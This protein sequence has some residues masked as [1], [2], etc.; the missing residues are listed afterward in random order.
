MLLTPVQN[1]GQPATPQKRPGLLSGLFSPD[2]RDRFKRLAIGLEGMTLNP[3]RSLI[4]MLQGD[5]DKKQTDEA[6]NRTIAWLKSLNT[7]QA[8][9]AAAAL[10]AG[11]ID[12]ST[13]VQMG[14][15]ADPNAA[16]L[17][18]TETNNR[19]I[20]WL[21]S[22]N[23]PQA[24]QAAEALGTGSID[25][26]SAVKMALDKPVDNSTALQQNIQYFMG[27]PFN[28][29]AEDAMKA[30]QGP[31]NG[32]TVNVGG[33][34]IDYGDPPKEMAWARNPDG[35][36]KLDERGIPV[37]MP[38]QNT[39]LATDAQTAA[40]AADRKAANA[41][42]YGDA[43]VRAID[44]LVGADGKPGT[45]A[46]GGLFDL[47]QAGIMGSALASM[48]INQEAVDVKNTLDTVTSNIAF[49]RLQAMRDA[50]VTG[51]ALGSV[52][53]NELALLMNSL[54]AVKQNTSPEKLIENL[55]EI[56]RIWSK[57]NNDP[58]ARAAYVAAGGAAG[59]GAA[60]GAAGGDG[61][62]VTGE[63]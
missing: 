45:L 63:N 39:P 10:E 23:T 17:K 9:K 18:A 27:P 52:T 44:E 7:P 28:M 19:T 35:S 49:G 2:N 29:S 6:T 50:S 24:M 58:V 22:M 61:F 47:P 59:S 40:A 41:E 46:S 3:N 30:A 31:S 43:A 21:K 56:K 34:G 15:S 54:G 48:G 42:V 51:G 37:A 5:L 1:A 11:S 60:T 26:A 33:S 32:T 12:A 20:A 62:A 13:A 57:I 16:D 25:A 4:G 8:A 38:I 55:K 53:E 36:V 14:M